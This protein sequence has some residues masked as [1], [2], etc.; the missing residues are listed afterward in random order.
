M[1]NIFNDLTKITVFKIVNSN[2]R[3]GRYSHEPD[4]G[5]ISYNEKLYYFKFSHEFDSGNTYIVYDANND[6]IYYFML[7]NDIDGDV[8]SPMI[9]EDK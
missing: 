6:P 4:S 3:S 1:S 2:P 7:Y 9:F 8:D 5:N